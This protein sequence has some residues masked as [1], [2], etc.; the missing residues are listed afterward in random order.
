MRRNHGA[1]GDMID[2]IFFICCMCLGFGI[3]MVIS[4]F[5]FTRYLKN[6]KRFTQEEV[7]ALIAKERRKFNR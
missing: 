1:V 4:T 2:T 3:G 6:N 7:N 5:C